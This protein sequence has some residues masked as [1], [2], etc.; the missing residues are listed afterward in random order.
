M[1]NNFIAMPGILKLL[2]VS[3]LAM[4]LIIISTINPNVKINVFGHYM[5]YLEWWTTGAGIWIVL[6]GSTSVAAAVLLLMRS[7]Y[8]RP[9]YLVATASTAISGLYIGKIAGADME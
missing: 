8:A 7:S 4:F 1:W 3:A 6:V 5:T 2:T 9:V